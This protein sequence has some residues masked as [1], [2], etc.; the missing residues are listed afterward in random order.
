M[1]GLQAC[2][3]IACRL[4][5]GCLLLSTEYQ[6]HNGACWQRELLQYLWAVFIDIIPPDPCLKQDCYS[7]TSRSIAR[8]CCHVSN[9]CHLSAIPIYCY[10]RVHFGSQLKAMTFAFSLKTTYLLSIRSQPVLTHWYVE[11]GG[12][13]LDKLLRKSFE[14]L[15]TRLCKNQAFFLL[16]H[17]FY[18]GLIDS[19]LRGLRCLD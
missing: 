9:W 1:K 13:K 14:I 18:N 8:C 4:K 7:G 17:I 3:N 16:I 12:F 19:T 6:I 2:W 15:E 11:Y 5:A 10:W